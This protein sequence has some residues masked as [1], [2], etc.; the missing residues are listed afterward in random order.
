MWRV[1]IVEDDPDSADI[2]RQHL[3]RYETEHGETFAVE[4][5]ASALEFLDESRSYDVVFL[6]IGLPGI[7]GM[8]AAELMRERDQLTPI[9]FVTDLAQYAVQGYAVGALDFMVKPVT[10]EDFDLRMG[11]ALRVMRRNARAIVNI[12][13]TD[14]LRV[15]DQSDIIYVEV[16]RHDL[17]WHIWEQHEGVTSNSKVDASARLGT[18]TAAAG[19]EVLR[20]R[21]SLTQAAEELGEECFC[22]ISASHLINMGQVSCVRRGS[23]VMSDGTEL[24]FSRS[25]RQKASETLARYVGGSI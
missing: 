18:P 24:S 13:T 15:I 7:N 20:V 17:Y 25:Y 12:R 8:E 21:G 3:S 22:R 2:L 9:I 14:G 5:V 19:T 1:L 10:Y 11:R 16:L 23:V 4:V 6:D